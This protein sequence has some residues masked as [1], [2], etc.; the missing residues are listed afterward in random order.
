MPAEESLG[1]STTLQ[2]NEG[3][4]RSSP[5]NLIIHQTV[6]WFPRTKILT[7]RSITQAENLYW[8]YCWGLVYGIKWFQRGI[9]RKKS[10]REC[11]RDANSKAEAS[12]LVKKR[13]ENK[14]KNRWGEAQTGQGSELGA[15]SPD[16]WSLSWGFTLPTRL[17]AP[18]PKTDWDF[19][20]YGEF[21]GCTRTWGWDWGKLE[22][23]VREGFW[24]VG[25]LVQCSKLIT[26]CSF[27]HQR[28]SIMNTG[29]VK[30]MGPTLRRA[31]TWSHALL[32]LCWHFQ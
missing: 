18:F 5:N 21:V 6:L 25:E 2:I 9:E 22:V 28:A 12:G 7:H 10:L 24:E 29:S 11:S 23:S 14:N 31:H 13:K 3:W 17:S 8:V 16:P 19:W 26:T 20:A 30:L 15:M 4:L 1:I 27:G 32:S